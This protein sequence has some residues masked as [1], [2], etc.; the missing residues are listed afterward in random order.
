MESKPRLL[1]D[2]LQKV[3]LSLVDI[4]RHREQQAMCNPAAIPELNR[5][6]TQE[7][8]NNR[9]LLSA[10]PKDSIISTG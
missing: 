1:S 8:M 2:L 6:L 3:A 4:R 7:I 5:N 10:M 9:S